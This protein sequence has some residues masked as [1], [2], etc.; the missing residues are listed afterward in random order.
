MAIQ[1]ATQSQLP[2][3]RTGE[4]FTAAME[5]RFQQR[6][7][8]AI[9]HDRLNHNLRPFFVSASATIFPLAPDERSVTSQ[10]KKSR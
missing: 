6:K 3:V 10:L 5:H 4:P 7:V 9:T 8:E 2:F 1:L